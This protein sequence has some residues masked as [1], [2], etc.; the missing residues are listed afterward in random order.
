MCFL[1]SLCCLMAP[2]SLDTAFSVSTSW[3][4]KYSHQKVKI[5][6]LRCNA[7]VPVSSKQIFIHIFKNQNQDWI[8]SAASL[9]LVPTPNKCQSHKFYFTFDFIC[10]FSFWSTMIYRNAVLID[11]WHRALA[12][13]T[14]N[15]KQ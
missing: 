13:Q 7:P 9:V 8:I 5:A 15:N 1:S 11:K 10:T 6:P 2:H 3:R 14:S 12:I 4:I